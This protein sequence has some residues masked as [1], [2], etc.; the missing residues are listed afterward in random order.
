MKIKHYKICKYNYSDHNYSK[1]WT[2]I[3]DAVSLTDNKKKN[4]EEYLKIEKQYLD[5]AAKFIIRYDIKIIEFFDKNINEETESEFQKI[6]YGLLEFP[7][8]ARKNS[9]LSFM[10]SI[11][12]LQMSL[13]GMYWAKLKNLKSNAYIAEGED[14][15]WLIGIPESDLSTL[16]LEGLFIYEHSNPWE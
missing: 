14:Y 16:E 7:F 3:W 12:I 10:E 13:R 9:I 8:N 6:Q 2:V 15:Y 1:D 11:Q 4:W 5:F